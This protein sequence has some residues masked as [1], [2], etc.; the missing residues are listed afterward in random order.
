[1]WSLK[2]AEGAHLSARVSPVPTAGSGEPQGRRGAGS[3]LSMLVDTCW[4]AVP[5]RSPHLSGLAPGRGRKGNQPALLRNDRREERQTITSH[6]FNERMERRFEGPDCSLS[7]ES[8]GPS[9]VSTPAPQKPLSP[10]RPGSLFQI[11][12]DGENFPP[13]LPSIRPASGDS[14]QTCL[15]FAALP[16]RLCRV[17]L[18]APQRAAVGTCRD[19]DGGREQVQGRSESEVQG[20]HVFRP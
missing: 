20:Q 14:T 17:F 19:R 3:P 13:R 6:F 5:G 11:E 18:R 7:W 16:G 1:M 12:R 15:G 2:G 9:P 4:P 10:R 8:A